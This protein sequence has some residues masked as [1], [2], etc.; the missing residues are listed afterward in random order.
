MYRTFFCIFKMYNT[1][2]AKSRRALDCF[3][4]FMAE[5]LWGYWQTLDRSGKKIILLSPLVG[6]PGAKHFYQNS[7][8]PF[9]T[10]MRV[11]EQKKFCEWNLSKQGDSMCLGN[12]IKYSQAVLITH[13][14]PLQ[15]L[16]LCA[17]LNC[18]I[19]SQ[20]TDLLVNIR[21]AFGFFDTIGNSLSK[22]ALCNRFHWEVLKFMIHFWLY[23]NNFAPA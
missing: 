14:L 10:K 7:T 22:L 13:W 23:L 2:W 17:Y 12:Y 11:T 4:I 20:Y 3:C 9:V 15:S 18:W 8:L 6:K 16:I 1:G 21:N 5:I 19:N